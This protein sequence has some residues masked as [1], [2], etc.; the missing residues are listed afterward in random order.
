MSMSSKEAN[1]IVAA[2]HLG[3]TSQRYESSGLGAGV[4]SSGH[5]DH[6]GASYGTYQL[7]SREGT[8]QEYLAQSR[9]GKEFAG[10]APATPAFDAKWKEV[11]ARDP[12]FGTDQ[13]DFIG[14]SHYGAQLQRLHDAGFDMS[15]RGR[16][17]QD[18]VWSTSVQFRNMTPGIF[19]GGLHE[20]FGK[21]VDVKALSDADIVGA[22]QDYKIAHNATLFSKS[23]E[24]QPNLRRRAEHERADLLNLAE[25]E[26]LAPRA[27]D[28]SSLQPSSAGHGAP[29][30]HHAP[31]HAA[32]RPSSAT[33]A[34]QELAHLGYTGLDGRLIRADGHA[35]RNTHHAIEQYQRDHHLPATG[36]LDQATQAR[37]DRDDRTMA[38]S[39]HPAHGLYA[40][41]LSAVAE[42]DRRL[43]VRG[44]SHS[45]ALAG[46]VAAEA[47]RA[48][49]THVD[50]VELSRDGKLAQAVQFRNG[51]D[52]WVTNHTSAPINL[53]SALHQSLEA[54]SDDARAAMASQAQTHE[55]S[56]REHAPMRAPVL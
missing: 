42:L 21:G 20:R 56:A 24:W 22:V 26:R 41:S 18:C 40:E 43:G 9:Y 39:T 23:P 19:R 52:V 35:G 6:G 28:P 44:S 31:P 3:Q 34:Q 5:H 37:L 32:P 53:A 55:H 51:A 14:R 4:V 1:D 27:I 38:S 13:H 12:A 11:A 10:L 50:R 15:G 2:W 8:V 54:S 36:R 47:A 16:A 17:V 7:S 29:A 25:A 46:V 48:G 45:I 30:P 49:M 33:H